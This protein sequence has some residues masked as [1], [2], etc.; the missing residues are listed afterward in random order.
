MSGEASSDADT[1]GW[2]FD[3]ASRGQG[4]SALPHEVS[5]RTP[6]LLL[7]LRGARFRGVERR[8]IAG[9]AHGGADGPLGGRGR[10]G[11]GERK[12][13]ILSP[14]IL[15]VVACMIDVVCMPGRRLPSG[16]AVGVG[17]WVRS[18]RVVSAT[19]TVSGTCTVDAIVRV[20]RDH[21]VGLG[22]LAPLALWCRWRQTWRYGGS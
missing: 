10:E 9:G 1:G 7:A 18:R 5:N 20:G 15:G 13:N 4:A 17:I 2:P 22:V 3:R 6:V 19:C 8:G 14:Y 11:L 16:R 21:G 12:G